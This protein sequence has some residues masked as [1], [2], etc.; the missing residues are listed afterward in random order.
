MLIKEIQ[1]HWAFA[2]IH[3]LKKIRNQEK[4]RG[5]RRNE[6]KGRLNVLEKKTCKNWMRGGGGVS[7]EYY[8]HETI[9]LKDKGLSRNV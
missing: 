8:T 5:G 2:A 3:S 7:G 4:I 9:K 6:S 1:G